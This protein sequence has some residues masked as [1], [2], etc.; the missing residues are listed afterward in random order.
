MFAIATFV[1]TILANAVAQAPPPQG[2]PPGAQAQQPLEEGPC[3]DSARSVPRVVQAPVI[4]GLQIVRIDQV[5][6]TATMTP[7][8]IAGFLYTTQDGSTWL[9]ERT[10]EYMS[11]ADATAIN[12]VLASTHLPNQNVNQFPPHTRYGVTTK[13]PQIF[14]VHIAP[15]AFPALRIE[16]VPCVVW[17]QTR[18]LPDPTL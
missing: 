7:G 13:Y 2:P 11:P 3:L 14:K 9:G 12:Q 1:L 5:V 16:L 4:R 17:P 15:D 6:S 18:A 8:S 10:A